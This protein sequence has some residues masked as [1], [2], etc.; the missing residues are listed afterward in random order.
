MYGIILGSA[1]LSTFV[2]AVLENKPVN[3]RKYV[4]TFYFSLIKNWIYYACNGK[5]RA[6]K[7]K[8]HKKKRLLRLN[9][10]I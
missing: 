6:I 10:I 4:E 7:V 9:P 5:K 8:R 1:N 3:Y 2:R